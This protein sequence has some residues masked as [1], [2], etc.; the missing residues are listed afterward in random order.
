MKKVSLIIGLLALAFSTSAA[1]QDDAPVTLTLMSTVLSAEVDPPPKDWVWSKAVKD[2]LNIDV[3]INWVDGANYATVLNTRAGTNDLPDID[4]VATT[5]LPLLAPQGILGDWG[6]LLE[7][8]PSYVEGH[9][10]TELAPIGKFNDVQYGLV[11]QTTFPYKGMVSVR[12]DWLDK[13]GLEA[14]KTTDEYLEVMKAFTTQ[15]PD[16]N[17]RNDTYGWSG[18]LNDDGSFGSFEPIFGAFDALGS[19]RIADGQIVPVA[20]STARR[21]ALEF[22]KQMV[23]AG[24]VDPDW[25]TQTYDDFRRK[26]ENGRVG[27]FFGDWCAVYCVANF[28]TFADANPDS[29]LVIIDPPVGPDGASAGN[30]YSQNGNIYAVSQKAIDEGKGEAIA[31]LFEWLGADGYYLTAY[32]P[33]GECW[34]RD[35]D[36]IINQNDE[37]SCRQQR[38]LATWAYKGSKEEYRGRYVTVTKQ[39]N[40]QTVDVGKILER[41]Y[42]YPKTDVTQFAVIPPASPVVAADMQ[43]FTAE[44]ELQFVLGQKSFDDWDNYVATLNGIG[45]EQYTAEANAAA[46]AT[47]LIP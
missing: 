4:R 44:N 39:S 14:P 27:L 36:G 6:P 12:Q 7:G 3:N 28:P 25:Q 42:V 41:S 29:R 26:W 38:A 45:L 21:Q 22:F 47:G 33:K 9:N 17:G 5:D 19:W 32:G 23:T 18:F 34:S 11:T 2:A 13:L 1:A 16:G 24:V 35:E 10:V 15:D 37:D 46:Q 31:R 20:T 40:G 8:M 43:R 30:T